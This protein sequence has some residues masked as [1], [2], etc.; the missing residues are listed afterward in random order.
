MKPIGNKL[1]IKLNIPETTN[2]SGIYVGQD[3]QQDETLRGTV[4]S[5]GNAVK[6]VVE[7]DI[8]VV[9]RFVAS[10]IYP[11]DGDYVL[12]DESDILAILVP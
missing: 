1:L 3:K 9:S 7:G 11:A 8:V 4:E 12:A 2:K 5:V 10:D 6:Q